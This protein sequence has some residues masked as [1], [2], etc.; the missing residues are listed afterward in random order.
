[1]YQGFP[2]IFLLSSFTIRIVLKRSTVCLLEAFLHI[3]ILCNM[4]LDFSLLTFFLF[5]FYCN[6]SCSWLWLVLVPT[7]SSS[8]FF[9]E[10]LGYLFVFYKAPWNYCENNYVL[11]QLL[12][13]RLIDIISW[14][15]RENIVICTIVP[16]CLI[17]DKEIAQCFDKNME[18][19]QMGTRTR[20]IKVKTK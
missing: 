14:H 2:H 17:E 5:S 1:M 15:L 9:I 11:S 16:W 3:N 4:I 13:Y 8:I 10:K 20:G 18:L 6:P 19:E 12:N 7:C